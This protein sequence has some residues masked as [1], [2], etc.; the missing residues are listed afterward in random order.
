MGRNTSV[1]PCTSMVLRDHQRCPPYIHSLALDMLQASGH[2]PPG[3]G[4]R[5]L[6][7]LASE[8]PLLLLLLLLVPTGPQKRPQQEL[9][10]L[11]RSLTWY[12]SKLPLL[13][14]CAR[15]RTSPYRLTPAASQLP[16]T[17]PT[18]TWMCGY[19]LWRTPMM[20]P[21]S[22]HAVISRSSGIVSRLMTRLWYR[23]A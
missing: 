23:Q 22:V 16:T 20:V 7:A 5:R 13:T 11:A 21:S 1:T 10:C 4:P 12:P 17:H 9:L 2:S 6:L 3:S 8:T 15:V 18:P 14:S 19:F